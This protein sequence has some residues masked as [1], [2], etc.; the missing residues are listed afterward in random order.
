MSDIKKTKNVKEK[1]EKKH[2]LIFL[3]IL[4]VGIAAGLLMGVISG[5]LTDNVQI[6][7]EVLAEVKLGLAYIVPVAAVV[8]NVIVFVIALLQFFKIKKMVKAWDGDD[9][10]T[11]CEIEY[12]LNWPLLFANVMMICNFIFFSVGVEVCEL[13]ELQEN[14]AEILNFVVMAT[15]IISYVFEIIITKLVVDLEKKLNPE[16]QGSIF[17][18]QFAKKWENSCDELEKQISYKVGF[19]AYKAGNK[20]CVVLWIISFVSQLMF[21]TGIF[22]VI[23]IGVIWLVMLISYSVSCMQAEKY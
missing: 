2:F 12:K 4:V 19:K 17:D 1:S 21:D 10:K 23:C 15:F 6:S 5:F 7:D 20:V 16:K 13:P 18:M 9:E 14:I 11:I 3:A 8:I 22:P